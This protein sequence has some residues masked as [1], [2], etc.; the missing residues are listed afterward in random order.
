MSAAGT[1]EVV[2]QFITR[3]FWVRLEF[4]DGVFTDIK[5]LSFNR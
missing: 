4:V 5:V 1:P 3:A 2:L